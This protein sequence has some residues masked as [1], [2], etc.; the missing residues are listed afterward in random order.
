MKFIGQTP[1]LNDAGTMEVA[2]STARFGTRFLLRRVL[3]RRACGVRFAR[4]IIALRSDL[5]FQKVLKRVLR[6]RSRPVTRAA[7]LHVRP[8]C[9]A[10]RSEAVPR[11]FDE[12]ADVA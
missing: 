9:G 2:I 5:S 4:Q 6:L 7:N 11:N 8:V 1:A 10:L 3:Q 12:L